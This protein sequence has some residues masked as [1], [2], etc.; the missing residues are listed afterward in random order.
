MARASTSATWQT[1]PCGA[2]VHRWAPPHRPLLRIAA[3]LTA[4]FFDSRVGALSADTICGKIP[5]LTPQQRA[6]CRSHP[7][8]M[9]AVG[10]GARLGIGECRHQFRFSRWNCSALGE[11][12]VF[13]QELPGGSREAA[14]AHAVMAAAVAYA[15]TAACGRGDR[16]WCGCDGAKQGGFY[17]A[18]G[19]CSADLSHSLEF[20]RLFV[21]AREVQR[22]ACTLMNLHNNAAGRKVLEEKMKTVCKCHGVLGSC[23]TRTCWATL[24]QFREVGS[25]LKR[26]YDEAVHVEPVHAGRYR[27]R[28]PAFLQA[29]R[30]RGHRKPLHTELVFTESSPSYCEEDRLTGSVG[31]RGRP[32]NRTSPHADGC[33]LLC[34][35]RGYDTRQYTR[36]WHC[37]CEFRWCCYVRCST[38]SEGAEEYT[39]K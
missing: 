38:C 17:D 19:G 6:L 21:D 4:A 36:S 9:V 3:A 22:S 8:A 39:C 16:S 25:A 23:T 28:Y 34:C 35:G 12:T 24:P 13:G 20:S 11:E 26:K 5:G 15:I 27:H 10:E 2:R 1:A 30:S 7:D 37:K 29:R 14:F 32:C 31:T 18:Q 33:E